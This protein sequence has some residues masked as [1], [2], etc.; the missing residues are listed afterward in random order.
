[1]IALRLALGRMLRY[2]G[3]ERA[4]GLSLPEHIDALLLGHAEAVW[5]G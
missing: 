1:M 2:L 3:S 4:L 5:L